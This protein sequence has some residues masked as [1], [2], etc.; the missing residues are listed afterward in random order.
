MFNLL[1][2]CVYYSYYDHKSIF[3]S[4]AHDVIS[5]YMQRYEGR[6]DNSVSFWQVLGKAQKVHE[7]FS[8]LEMAVSNF[9]MSNCFAASK[10]RSFVTENHQTCTIDSM[11]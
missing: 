3:Q 4:M 11:F 10:F 5:R 7:L 6:E 2:G 9:R 8:R 1:S